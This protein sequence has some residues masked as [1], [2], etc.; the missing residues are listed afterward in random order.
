[1]TFALHPSPS[2]PRLGLCQLR[3]G[4]TIKRLVSTG[5]GTADAVSTIARI[6]A[7]QA[8]VVVD[9]TPLPT[10]AKK[11]TGR[12][13]VI[14]AIHELSQTMRQ[15]SSSPKCD[16]RLLQVPLLKNSGVHV[17]LH[18]SPVTF[19]L[20]DIVH[21]GYGCRLHPLVDYHLGMLIS[22]FQILQPQSR[23]KVWFVP[24]SVE[25]SRFAI[26][27]AFGDR[28][29]LHWH[30]ARDDIGIRQWHER[31]KTAILAR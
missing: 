15:W 29:Q 22:K 18:Q 4:P 25:E 19:P 23:V 21:V 2:A 5:T 31:T 20:P 7:G 17:K 3:R 12:D 24:T 27:V 28:R 1:M 9:S 13:A 30:H 8:V 26:V 11:S 10:I 6:P 16:S 14:T